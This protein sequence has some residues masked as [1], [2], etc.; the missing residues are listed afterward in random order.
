MIF[1]PK[2]I[3]SL[4]IKRSGKE[5]K[6]SSI[7]YGSI[8]KRNHTNLLNLVLNYKKQNMMIPKDS[9]ILI[10]LMDIN[11]FFRAVAMVG[12]VEDANKA[13]GIKIK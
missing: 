2:T 10:K 11:G 13:N 6:V 5:E 1:L 8:P 7:K 4:N 9:L 12:D 3:E